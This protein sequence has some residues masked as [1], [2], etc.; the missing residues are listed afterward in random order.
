MV[1]QKV[2][3]QKYFSSMQIQNNLIIINSF[4]RYILCVLSFLG[5]ALSLQDV[6]NNLGSSEL[7]ED[8]LMLDLDLS[9]DQ[10]HR[11]G[12]FLGKCVGETIRR[13]R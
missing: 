9:D 5:F 3:F 7:D 11:H 12:N 13:Y 1:R 10:R 2:Q 4:V 8:D 6:L